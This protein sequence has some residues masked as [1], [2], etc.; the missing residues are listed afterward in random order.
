M[1]HSDEE[2]TLRLV[3]VKQTIS[4]FHTSLVE[5]KQALA[6]LT[7]KEEDLL[8]LSFHSTLEQR[9]LVRKSKMQIM[10]DYIKR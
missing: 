10:E 7:R 6:A 3:P 4:K 1:E 9:V 2:A 8:G 5:Y